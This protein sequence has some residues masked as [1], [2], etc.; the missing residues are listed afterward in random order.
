MKG[1]KVDLDDLVAWTVTTTKT[2][3]I[4]LR[5]TKPPTTNTFYEQQG[6]SYTNATAATNAT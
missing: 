6:Q 3:E 5:D 4:L 2:L 1:L